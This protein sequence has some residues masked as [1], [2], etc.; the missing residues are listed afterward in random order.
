MSYSTTR[1]SFL[2]ASLG[3]SA[4]VSLG[5]HVPAFLA[6][7]AQAAAAQG[8]DP[9]GNVLVVLQLSGGNDGLN[10]VVPYSDPEYA[11]NRITLRQQ[12]N[13]VLKI[14]D[15]IGLHPQLGG[16]AGLLEEQRLAI[17]QGVGY[18]N[19]DRS[20][21]RSMDIWH[22]AQPEVAK[23]VDGWLGRCQEH[24]P[25]S[26]GRDVPAL[27]LGD[28]ELP[29]ALVSQTRP[30]PSVK[31]LESFRL[32]TAGGAAP[33]AALRELAGA[34]RSAP[35]SLLDFLQQ[36]TLTA[37]SSSEQVQESLREDSSPV[38][39]P[40]FGLAQRLKSVAQLI[41]A[42]LGT[43]IYYVS[44]DGFDTHANQAQGHAALLN[45]L[46]ESVKA[47]QA[48]LAHRG[49][50][51]R[52][53]TLSFSEFGRRVHENASQGTDHGAAAPLFLIGGRVQSGLIGKQ[54]S[55]S[56]LDGEGDLKFHT[57][58]RQVYAAILDRW[59][60]CSSEA[61]LGGVFEPAAVLRD[62]TSS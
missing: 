61:V 23:P 52:V 39:Y 2:R 24:F 51:D 56:D 53:L 12:P 42:G 17:V 27:H 21:F 28:N 15:E 7:S 40:G 57:D 55:L 49:H 38:K 47:F 1:R 36:S 62:A 50:V 13:Q 4:L 16:F 20:H 46:A 5:L 44:L 19:P 29:L 3:S 9:T 26:N 18:P 34:P 6:R 25:Q 32:R 10:T 59:L 54:P 41:D 60:G 8:N 43:R 37:Y 45:E 48:D 31:S 11:K 33:L 14:N 58:F 22:S 35:G 30:I